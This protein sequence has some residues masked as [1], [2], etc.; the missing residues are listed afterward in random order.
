MLRN[1]E[2]QSHHG[3]QQ[4]LPKSVSE[5]GVAPSQTL[6]SLQSPTD[7]PHED[8]AHVD[9]TPARE[10]SDGSLI[11]RPDVIRAVATILVLINLVSLVGFW[12]LYAK[13]RD[14]TLQGPLRFV[15]DVN[16][17]PASEL[18][19]LPGIGYELANRIVEN[20]EM[21]GPYQSLDD[22]NR[23]RGIGPKTLAQIQPMIVFGIES[24]SLSLP[25]SP[26]QNFVDPP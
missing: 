18:S 14:Q 13:A 5:K 24:D 25:Q 17:A 4:V 20:R 23:V 21:T 19:L 12:R 15:T 6:N 10:R 11:D 7:P 3:L 26:N 16:S 22:L 8:E 2:L 9:G 1:P